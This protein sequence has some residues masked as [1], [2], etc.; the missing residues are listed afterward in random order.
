MM[1][2]V[3]RHQ[4]AGS[5]DHRHLDASR[6]DAELMAA[7]KQLTSRPAERRSQPYAATARRD[8]RRGRVPAGRQPATPRMVDGRY[9]Q[10]F[11]NVIDNALLQPAGLAHGRARPRAAQRRSSS[12]STTRAAFR[13]NLRSIFEAL[14]LGRPTE[15]FS[16]H[17][18]A[19][20][21]DLPA[22]HGDIRFH[23]RLNRCPPM[24]WGWPRAGRAFTIACRPPVAQTSERGRATSVAVRRGEAGARCCCGPSGLRQIRPSPALIDAGARL[25]ADDQ[26]DSPGRAGGD[27]QPASVAA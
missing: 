8:R 24:D 25:I 5:A 14:L 12:P 20:P 10:V 2:I 15:H 16:Q 21:F 4:P 18:R 9:G 1:A 26:T 22:D 23:L 7:V 19:R 6:L 13:G 27:R 17:S 3:G 11:R